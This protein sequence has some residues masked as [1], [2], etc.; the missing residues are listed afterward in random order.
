MFSAGRTSAPPPNR[1]PVEHDFA[2]PSSRKLTQGVEHAP[3]PKAEPPKPLADKIDDGKAGQRIRAEGERQAGD[4]DR[5]AAG[6][7]GRTPSAET[8]SEAAGRKAEKPK[9]AKAKP[10]QLADELKKEEVKKPPKPEKKQP[11][12]KPDQIA[13]ELKKEEAKKRGSPRQVRRRPGR[14]AAR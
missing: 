10:D 1:L 2:I 13:E 11:E 4:Q 14:G 6:A 3:E 9:E 5:R 12:F 7:A 8:G